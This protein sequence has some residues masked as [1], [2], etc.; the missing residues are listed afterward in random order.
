MRAIVEFY[1]CY[2]IS[3]SLRLVEQRRGD[4][5]LVDGKAV[6]VLTAIKAHFSSLRASL[7]VGK[8]CKKGG[9]IG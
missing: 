5:A 3:Q 6:A 4:G 7:L 1:L 8:Q 2:A 9:C